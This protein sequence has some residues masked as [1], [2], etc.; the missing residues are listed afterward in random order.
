MILVNRARVFWIYQFT[1]VKIRLMFQW[2]NVR[3]Y[4]KQ[5]AWF[6]RL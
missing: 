5:E 2:D 1:G 4:I 3:D 6:Q